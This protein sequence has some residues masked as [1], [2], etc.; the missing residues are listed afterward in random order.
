MIQINSLHELR[1]ATTSHAEE[2]LIGKDYLNRTR[3]KFNQ[4]PQV[5][6]TTFM[7]GC[8]FAVG[9]LGAMLL[10]GESFKAVYVAGL[11]I[12]GLVIA[13][14]LL[15]ILAHL[16]FSLILLCGNFQYKMT[17]QPTGDI[18]LQKKN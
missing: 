11:Y 14:R 5:K 7:I 17:Y 9:G 15:E 16:I 4:F 12:M 2:I 13:I 18:L 10:Y 1:K 6:L 8:F 3:A